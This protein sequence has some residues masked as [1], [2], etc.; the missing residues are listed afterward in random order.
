MVALDGASEG[1]VLW[2]LTFSRLTSVVLIGAAVAS[3]RSRVTVGRGDAAPL[4][5][6][7]AL[8][9]AASALFAVATTTGLLSLVGVMG[10]LYPVITIILAAV[11]LRE[12]PAGL[13]RVGAVGA[14]VGVALIAGG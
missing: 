8:D 9:L 13:Q 6:V 14:L 5:A 10:S 2:A 3:L 1:G 12:R 11:V 4:L 7:G